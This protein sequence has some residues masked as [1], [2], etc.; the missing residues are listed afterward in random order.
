MEVLELDANKNDVKVY[1]NRGFEKSKFITLH[2][3]LS[4][5]DWSRY[6]E[7]N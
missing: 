5:V 4:N 6:Q 3:L 7:K 2:L 1:E